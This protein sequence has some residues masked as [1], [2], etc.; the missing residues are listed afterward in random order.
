MKLITNKDFNQLQH[1]LAAFDLS[2]FDTALMSSFEGF[3]SG[4]EDDEIDTY[5]FYENEQLVGM[6]RFNEELMSEIMECEDDEME[7]DERV[8]LIGALFVRPDYRRKK[9]AKQLVEFAVS[10]AKTSVIVADPYNHTSQQFFLSIGF[11][12]DNEFDDED[13]WM[14]YLHI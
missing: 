5:G 7:N 2:D 10:Q 3:I 8:T 1:S 13:E 11:D 4:C 12:F 6:I 9:M 14:V